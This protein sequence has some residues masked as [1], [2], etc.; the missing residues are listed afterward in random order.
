MSKEDFEIISRSSHSTQV[1]NLPGDSQGAGDQGR[2]APDSKGP[3]TGPTTEPGKL[4]AKQ[5]FDEVVKAFP[6]RLV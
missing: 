5:I 2:I 6:V 1:I 3:I 4:R